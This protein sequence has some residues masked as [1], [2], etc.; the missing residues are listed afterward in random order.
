MYLPVTC[1]SSTISAPNTENAFT[2]SE[3]FDTCSSLP[4]ERSTCDL[5]LREKCAQK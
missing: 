5:N 2:N 3:K 4:N 1:A